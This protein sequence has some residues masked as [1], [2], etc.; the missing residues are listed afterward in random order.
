MKGLISK[1]IRYIPRKYL[2]Y[3]TGVGTKVLGTFYRGKNY[4]CPVCN[5]SYRKFLPYGRIVSRQN[6][7]CPGC[8]SLERHRLIWLYL[9]EDTDFFTSS[10]KVLHIAPEPCFLDRFKQLTNLEYVTADLESPLADVKMDIHEM[11]FDDNSFD[12]V[13]CNHVLEHVED[14]IKALSEIYRV[15]KN[16]GWAILQVPFF[17]PL[18]NTT[19]N[20][21]TITDPIEREKLFGQDDHVRKYGKDYAERISSVGFKVKEENFVSTFNE[22][23][24]ISYGLPPNEI[25]YVGVKGTNP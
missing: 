9:K 16:G 18:P 3:F 1:T 5:H 24:L 19:I 17:Y 25:V 10:K 7:L 12:V 11:P 23:E 20:D 22:D 21:P 14:D 2:H 6:A 13:I 8:L 15:L 4:N